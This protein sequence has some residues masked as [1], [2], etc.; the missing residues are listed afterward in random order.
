MSKVYSKIEQDGREAL[1]R[2]LNEVPGIS[3]VEAA[4]CPAN[5]FCDFVFRVHFWEGLSR[6][7]FVEVN[8]RGERRFVEAFMAQMKNRA[9]PGDCVFIA[10][11]LSEQSCALLKDQ[12]YNYMDLSGNCRIATQSVYISVS[13]QPNRYLPENKPGKYFDRSSSAASKVLRTMLNDPD[14]AWKVKELVEASDTSL[15]TVSNVK[16]FLIDNAWAEEIKSSAAGGRVTG[17]RLRNVSELLRAWAKEYGKRSGDVQEY[18]TL[19]SVPEFERSATQWR[20]R[21]GRVAY[22]GGFS[23][24]ARYAPVVRYNRAEVYVDYQD[25]SEFIEDMA[26]NAVSSG[27]NV[28]VML[29]TDDTELMYTRE[30]DGTGLT[31]PVQAILDLMTRPGRGEEAAE[32]IIQKEFRDQ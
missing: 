32:A 13:G 16:R 5:D 12:G 28:L 6:K 25:L 26:L 1:C 3:E 19:D 9:K 22:L 30:I 31:S 15:G 7:L 29:P 8:R 2:L 10:P 20:E 17:F 24:A 27:G 11:Y 4:K 14:K 18:Y 23:A 21:H